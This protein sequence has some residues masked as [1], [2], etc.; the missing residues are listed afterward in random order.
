MEEDETKPTDDHVLSNISSSLLSSSKAIT[1]MSAWGQESAFSDNERRDQNFV[2]KDRIIGIV[3]VVIVQ[4]IQLKAM[5]KGA[6]S[7]P[8]CKVSLGKDKQKTKIIN[9]TLNP[10]WRESLDLSWVDNAKDDI[11]HF[12]LYDWNM[13]GKDD[14]LGRL[15]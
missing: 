2:T 10:K 7:D 14:F 12:Q 5:D 8:Y 3:H 15:N 11:L 1:K 9:N 13:A 6:N 4:A